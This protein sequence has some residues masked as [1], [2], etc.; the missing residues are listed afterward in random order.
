MCGCEWRLLDCVVCV[1]MCVLCVLTMLIVWLCVCQLM[2]VACRVCGCVW[3]VLC[4][5]CVCVCGRDL[6]CVCVRLSVCVRVV[7][8]VCRVRGVFGVCRVCDRLVVCARRRQNPP[9]EETRDANDNPEQ[10][11]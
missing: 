3:L 10:G 1:R 9:S 5:R 4:A 2:R 6:G 7:G 8:C 11:S